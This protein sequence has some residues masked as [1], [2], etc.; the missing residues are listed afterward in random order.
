[1]FQKWATV[2]QPRTTSA[3]R[4]TSSGVRHE[5]SSVVTPD[6]SHAATCSLTLPA[7]PTMWMSST[8]ASGAEVNQVTGA[9]SQQLDDLT[10][11]DAVSARL[12]R[13]SPRTAP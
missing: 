5:S 13:E 7:S 1:M 3:T 4:R 10:N 6:S 12:L 11:A 2:R 8:S 9:L